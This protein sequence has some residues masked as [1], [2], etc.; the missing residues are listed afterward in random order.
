M[1]ARRK[2]A[3][4]LPAPHK[5]AKPRVLSP[6]VRVSKLNGRDTDDEGFLSPVIQKEAITGWA[7]AH[8]VRLTDWHEEL[9]KSGKTIER[10][11]LGAALDD[12]VE[13]GVHRLPNRL[14]G[15]PVDDDL[16]HGLDPER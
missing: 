14:L 10:E 5:P 12:G 4:A 8:K 2:P 11:G 15:Q 3:V 13:A 16:H 9:D 7:K 6:V 1:T